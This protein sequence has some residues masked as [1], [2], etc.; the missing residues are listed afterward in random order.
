MKRQH[1]YN[2]LISKH[3]GNLYQSVHT[4]ASKLQQDEHDFFY[5]GCGCLLDNKLLLATPEGIIFIW[6]C[7]AACDW[8]IDKAGFLIHVFN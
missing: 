1:L 3:A 8:K 5:L 7:R 2:T 4:N 6:A